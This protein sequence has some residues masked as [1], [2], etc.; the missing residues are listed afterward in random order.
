MVWGGIRRV[1]NAW[2]VPPGGAAPAASLS[3]ASMNTTSASA[4]RSLLQWMRLPAAAAVALSSP[5]RT[6]AAAPLVPV[7]AQYGGPGCPVGDSLRCLLGSGGVREH[8]G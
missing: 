6:V 4:A 2:A 7:A 5:A 1:E 8:F 3:L